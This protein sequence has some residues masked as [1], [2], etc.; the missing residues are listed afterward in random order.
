MNDLKMILSACNTKNVIQEVIL[1]T[2][3]A[4]PKGLN[5]IKEARAK[6]GWAIDD[7][8]SRWLRE[9]S[10]I[11]EPNPKKNWEEEEIHFV[12]KIGTWKRFLAG[13]AIKAETFK[14]FCQ[15]LGLNWEEVVDNTTPTQP[16]CENNIASPH[17]DWGEAPDVSKFYG[18]TEELKQL[19]KAI[20]E[21]RC[22]LVALLAQ[23]GIGKTALS[24]KLAQQIQGEFKYVIWRSLRESPPL[25]K[26]LTDL[27]KFLS[28]QQEIT[29]P[30]T[31]GEQIM[32]LIHHLRSSRCLVVLDNAESILQSGI[33]A[34]CYREGYEE[35]G[36]LFKRVGELD[37]ESCLILTSREQPKE[38]RHLAGETLPVRILKLTGLKAEAREIFIAKGIHGSEQDFAKLISL[39]RGNPQALKLVSSTIKQTFNGSINH[40]LENGAIVFG[41]IS[42]LLQKQFDRLSEV[43]QSLMYWLAINR[44]QVLPAQL[45]DDCVP[46]LSMPNIVEALDS[47]VCRCLIQPNPTGFTLQNVVMEYVTDRFVAQ[48]I[49][50]L[51][52]SEFHLF[53]THALIKASAKDYVRETQIRLI[54]KLIL[55]YLVKNE[56][57]SRIEQKFIQII[58]QLRNEE[59][60]PNPPLTKGKELV[61]RVDNKEKELVSR[62]DKGG[63]RGV[64]S[65]FA[66]GITPR[67]GYAAG[68]ILNLLVQLQTDLTNYDFSHL[69]IW[70]AY[71][72]GVNLPR[73]NFA[74]SD[75]NKSVFSQ[76]IGSIFSVAFSPDQKLLA[77]GGS[78]G[79]IRIWQVS[80]GKQILAW[81]AHGDWIRCVTFSH[82]GK[83]IASGSNDST[84]II[85]DSKTGDCLKILR[86]HKDWVWSVSFVLGKHLLV[87]ASSDHTAKVWSIDL[88]ICIYTF[89]EPEDQ[90]WSAAFS[91][92]G[93]TL[94]TGSA[95][96][97]KLWNVWT[98]QCVKTFQDNATRVRSLSFSPDGKTL[99]G[100]SDDRIIK[101][102]DVD[103]GKCLKTLKSATT[104]RLW[105]V[106]YSPDGQ[107][108]ISGSADTIQIWNVEKGEC[109]MTLQEPQHRAR[110]ITCS[111]DGG[112]IAVG[113]DDQLIRLW[114]TKTG[115][116]LRTLQG[117]TN[118][119]WTIAFQT[120][121]LP[122]GA[123][124]CLAS[125]S[126]DGIVR[127][128]DA[129]TG[130]CIKTL[131]GHKNRIRS[132]DF[133][134]DGR[135]LAT[136]SHDRTIK[137]WDIS[138]GECI[139]TL[140]GHVDWVVSVMFTNNNRSL[141]SAGDDQTV[142]IWDIHTN[143]SKLLREPDEEWM[144]AFACH[145]KDEILAVGGS[146]HAVSLWNIQTGQCLSTLKGHTNRIRA[147]AF[148]STGELL[149]T[150]SDDLT[151][152]LWNLKT[153]KCLK[154]LSGHT[155]Q[156]RSIIFLSVTA[157]PEILVT[158]GDDR[159]I[160]LWNIYTGKCLKILNAH[161]QPI[162]S[163]CYSPQMDILFSCSEDETI[164]LWD[165]KTGNC[166]KTLRIPRPYEGMNMTGV[167]GLTQATVETLKILGAVEKGNNIN[168]NKKS[169]GMLGKHANIY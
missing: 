91:N 76:S 22:R 125:G 97:V 143:E 26:L 119:I 50:E 29:L 40:F 79:Q 83:L 140:R 81:Q 150:S 116:P 33:R 166:I 77:T 56:T 15:V 122:Q 92:N 157:Q 45:Q 4:S 75:L 161:S 31:V 27:I 118:R 155:G 86:G 20:V 120:L 6:K 65:T 144:W 7:K 149:A 112:I 115:E 3:K 123:F 39:Y 168:E 90:V 5:R 107:K 133:S 34:G 37:H 148:N 101:T 104:T 153:G 59:P 158:S 35:Y 18:R 32:R 109:L 111:P 52:T 30:E 14:A 87:S 147:I 151:V 139:K 114:D 146:S 156:I 17:Q 72:Q 64:N 60:H 94:A 8:R 70:Q 53:K 36:E 160:R 88:G 102:W 38:I 21:N 16:S 73:V 44:E 23:G 82:D 13:K 96:S 128:W 137:L 84:I 108:L 154:I 126:D 117:Y 58:S 159:T 135:I 61:S 74:Y 134:P 89:N 11:L 57:K 10:K 24:V 169:D 152:R 1:R 69:T 48:V 141:I 51:Q 110:S 2:H 167:T 130:E 28:N 98:R 138:N 85:W 162:W 62:V 67:V 78:D 163:V 142:L 71:L 9:A 43:E 127:L 49:Q 47:L 41:D 19:K 132:I 66:T 80:N 93:Y 54:L 106:K 113:S 121:H 63:L 99:V 129:K 145:P 55:E 164:K 105:S 100:S 95:T 12:V 25:E 124:F 46:R 165:I 42:E 103:S 68:N 131:I 136:G